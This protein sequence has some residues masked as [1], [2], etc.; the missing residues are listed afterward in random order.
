MGFNSAFKGLNNPYKNTHANNYVKA[1]GKEGN[2]SCDAHEVEGPA[3]FRKHN[4]SCKNTN[5]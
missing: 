3:A 2:L 4:K 5:F 1:V